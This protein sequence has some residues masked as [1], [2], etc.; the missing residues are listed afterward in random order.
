MSECIHWSRKPLIPAEVY[1]SEDKAQFVDSEITLTVGGIEWTMLVSKICTNL[2][3]ESPAFSYSKRWQNSI[4]WL[5]E[6]LYVKLWLQRNSEYF[7]Y[8]RRKKRYITC[9]ITGIIIKIRTQERCQ[10]QHWS[11][12]YSPCSNLTAWC[13]VKRRRGGI[14]R[15]SPLC[16][17]TLTFLF[18]YNLH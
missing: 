8:L 7:P 4:R 1:P 12:F 11:V 10:S 6:A 15:F 2:F 9:T 18:R 13:I 16:L 17:F 3:T 14:N 5:W